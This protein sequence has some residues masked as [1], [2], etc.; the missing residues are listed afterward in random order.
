MLGKTVVKFCRPQGTRCASL[1]TPRHRP[2][3]TFS[4]AYRTFHASTSFLSFTATN[5]LE[6]SLVTAATDTSHRLQF[7]RALL[8]SEI[9]VLRSEAVGTAEEEGT[10]DS[11]DEAPPMVLKQWYKDDKPFLVLPIFSSLAC[12]Q[13]GAEEDALS[14]AR[15]DA[16]TFFGVT[17]G[18]T[19][20]L[21]PTL[22]YGKE[23]QR[24]EIERMLDGSIFQITEGVQEVK[25]PAGTDV[26]MGQPST[27]PAELV[28]ALKEVFSEADGIEAAY[29]AHTFAPDVDNKPH[30]VIGIES[31]DEASFHAVLGRAAAAT[32]RVS[33]D[34]IDFVPMAAADVLTTYMRDKTKPFY[35]RTD[36]TSST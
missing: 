35:D 33:S 28:T 34:V 11:E 5:D 14:Y 32:Q 10:V 24:E 31:K 22:A 8:D 18:A 20:I 17:K 6:Q 12:L 23:L 16:R 1:V 25:A 36:G 4:S 15:L 7:Y 27:Y 3:P 2:L 21:N 30:S 13:E 29:L 9:Y 26:M 19:V